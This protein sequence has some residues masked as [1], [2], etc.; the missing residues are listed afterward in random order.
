MAF[1]A[2]RLLRPKRGEPPVA[3]RL[4]G[5]LICLDV[6]V[7]GGFH[8]WWI[9]EYGTQYGLTLFTA[10]ANVLA[11]SIALCLLLHASAWEGLGGRRRD[12]LAWPLLAA[13]SVGAGYLRFG[14]E[15]P[16]F[17]NLATY[18]DV[19]IA[20]AV[21]VGAW[22]TFHLAKTFTRESLPPAARP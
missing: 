7:D 5:A 11:A 19:G 10:L 21:P 6:L 17:Q 22:L 4:V 13:V 15:G 8:L 2:W 14:A 18:L 16:I 20:I 1:L 3:C 9:G 12:F